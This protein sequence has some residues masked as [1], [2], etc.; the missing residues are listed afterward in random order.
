MCLVASRAQSSRSWQTPP[1]QMPYFPR[2][3]P[4]P[5]SRPI[6]GMVRYGEGSVDGTAL[7][8][9]SSPDEVYRKIFRRCSIPSTTAGRSR[10]ARM[11]R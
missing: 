9:N 1:S 6:L 3:N 7:W 2:L 8:M 11:A 10:L 4:D 5:V